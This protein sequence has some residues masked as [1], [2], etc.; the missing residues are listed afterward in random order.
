LGSGDTDPFKFASKEE[1][2]NDTIEIPNLKPR[3][4]ATFEMGSDDDES[5]EEEDEEEDDDDDEGD[6]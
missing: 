2:S 4:G 6:N 3:T 5:E 1:K